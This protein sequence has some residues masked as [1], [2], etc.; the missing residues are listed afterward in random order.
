M[1]YIYSDKNIHPNYLKIGFT[2]RDDVEERIQEQYST[3]L[4]TKPTYVLHYTTESIT[5]SGRS[6][7]DKD[8]HIELKKLGYNPLMR[9]SGRESEWYNV[10]LNTVINIIDKIKNDIP[11]ENK[12]MA[13]TWNDMSNSFRQTF[14]RMCLENGFTFEQIAAE[15]NNTPESD[16]LAFWWKKNENTDFTNEGDSKRSISDILAEAEDVCVAAEKIR[17]LRAEADYLESKMK[18]D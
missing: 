13:K 11:K 12:N 6:F 17:K 16:Y 2:T 8:V 3:A 15:F 10:D 4:F 14:V 1:I 9:S 5:N 18:K 7:T